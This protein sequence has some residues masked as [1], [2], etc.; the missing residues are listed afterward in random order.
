MKR[1]ALI[2]A[3]FLLS[4]CQTT[5]ERLAELDAEFPSP[6]AARV[7][8]FADRFEAEF[9]ALPTRKGVIQK[10]FVI[11][12][13]KSAANVILFAGGHGALE[14]RE[15][16]GFLSIGWGKGNLLVRTRA[17]FAD[18]G[19]TVAVVDAPSDMLGRGMFGGFRSSGDHVKD[20]E[21]VIAYLKRRNGL[22][23]W[24]VGTSR[25]TESAA[26]VAIHTRAPIGGLVL[27]SSVTVSTDN[28]SAIDGFALDRIRVP[29]QIVYH[30]Q[31]GCFVTPAEGNRAIASGLINSPKVSSRG[32][33]GGAPPISGPCKARSA[34][35]FLGLEDQVVAAIADF[36]KRN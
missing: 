16:A 4:A 9:V 1:C 18:N 3:I 21:A 5:G 35:G 22:P 33:T 11:R 25:G 17:R 32:F 14:L 34:H 20:I 26:F 2:A 36:I 29:V 28:G 31:D 13:K 24:L 30:E 12:P 19:L 10:F 23:V 8:S 27:T 6:G 15:D 7:S